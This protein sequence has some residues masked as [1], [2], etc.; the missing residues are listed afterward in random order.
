MNKP[1]PNQNGQSGAPKPTNLNNN[2]QRNGGQ[3]GAQQTAAKPANNLDANKE[4]LATINKLAKDA[5]PRQMMLW[6]ERLQ[7]LY[8]QRKVSVRK[9]LKDQVGD[10]LET[11]GYTIEELFGARNLPSTADLAARA[12]SKENGKI[13][14]L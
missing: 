13:G 4:D 5:T 10:L 6:I 9:E 14:R 12:K 11:N 1:I 2:I 3:N 7:E 8:D